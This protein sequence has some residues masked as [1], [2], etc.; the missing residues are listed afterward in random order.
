MKKILVGALVVASLINATEIIVAKEKAYEIGKAAASV[1]NLDPN[2]TYESRKSYCN[3]M[4]PNITMFG[5]D[6][7]KEVMPEAIKGC[8]DSIKK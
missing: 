4:I 7:R 5:V 2:S 6:N 1:T 3:E 8:L